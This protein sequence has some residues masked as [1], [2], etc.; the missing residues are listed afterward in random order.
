MEKPTVTLEV[1]SSLYAELQE[2]ATAEQTDLTEL[3]TRLVSKQREQHQP[4][5]VIA[6]IGAYQSAEPLIDDIP[7]SEDPE[8]YAMAA[9][10]GEHAHRKHAWEIAPQRYVKGA[11]GN[12]MRRDSDSEE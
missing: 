9:S 7:V 5:P 2:L 11:D 12:A 1:P 10:M 8:L 4:D 6:L 3:L